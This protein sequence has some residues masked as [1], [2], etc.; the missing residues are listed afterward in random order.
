MVRAGEA[1]AD[2]S[3]KVIIDFVEEGVLAEMTMIQP[4]GT[5]GIWIPRN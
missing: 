1:Q 3:V 5:D 4:Y 2:G